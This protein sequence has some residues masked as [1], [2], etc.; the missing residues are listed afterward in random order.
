MTPFPSLPVRP[1]LGEGVE[2]GV[3]SRQALTLLLG[4]GRTRV[5]LMLLPVMAATAG[6]ISPALVVSLTLPSG[7]PSVSISISLSLPSLVAQTGPQFA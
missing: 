3:V 2:A 1:G 7:P 4:P 6:P 5:V